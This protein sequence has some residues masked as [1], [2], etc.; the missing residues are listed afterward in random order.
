MHTKQLLEDISEQCSNELTLYKFN[1]RTL[2]VSDKYRSGRID[3]LNYALKLIY[4]FFEQDRLLKHQFHELLLSELNDS[5]MLKDGDY[6]QG[7]HDALRSI[8]TQLEN[9][10]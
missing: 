9:K 5:L 4:Y 10:K 3:A 8:I 7:L 1:K 6:R 2:L